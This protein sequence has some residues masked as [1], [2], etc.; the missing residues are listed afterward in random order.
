M[1]NKL[2]CTVLAIV[3][4]AGVAGCNSAENVKSDGGKSVGENSVVTSAADSVTDSEEGS[5]ATDKSELKGEVKSEDT[6]SFEGEINAV[7]GIRAGDVTAAADSAK[8]RNTIK[9]PTLPEKA[10]EKP[11]VVADMNGSARCLSIDQQFFE[12]LGI[13]YSFINDTVGEIAHGILPEGKNLNYA[14]DH[15]EKLHT[16]N[17]HFLVLQY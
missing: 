13:Q 10:A 5:T 17:K 1:K 9:A 8:P 3:L 6:Y 2:L 16:Q 12:T 7:E 14:A 4:A 11:A 15:L